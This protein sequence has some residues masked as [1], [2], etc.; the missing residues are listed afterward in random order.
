M[1]KA[2]LLVTKLH[3]PSLPAKWIKRPQLGQRLNEGLELGRPIT[4]ISAPAGFG[5]TTCVS[6]WLEKTTLPYSWLSLDASDDDPR[7]FF[8]YFIAALQQI[9]E[10]LGKEIEGVMLSG[11]LPPAEII[12]TKLMIDCLKTATPFLVI[13]DDFHLIQDRFI[14]QVFEHLLSNF[15]S[16]LHL[17]LITREDPS[18]P[19]G[20]IR[21]NNQLTE[22]RARD[23]RFTGN[24]IE[25]FLNE[26]MDLSLS[27]ADISFLENKTEGWIVGLQLAGLSIRDQ[28]NPSGFISGLSGSHRFILSYL[29]EQVLN[30]QPEEIQQFLLQTS[31]LDKLNAALCNAVTRHSDSDALLKRVLNANLFLIPLDDEQQWFR[32][33][34]LFADLLRNLQNTHRKEKTAELHRRASQWYAQAGMGSE[35]IQHALTAED[36]AA[37]VE[38]LENYAMGMIMQ[39]YAKTVN[40]WV[41]AIP[42]EWLSQSPR[43]HLAFAWMHL[44]RGAHSEVIQYLTQLEEIISGSQLSEE[45]KQSL[46]AEWLVMQSLLMNKYGKKDKSIALAEEALSITPEDHH[47]V[48]SLAYFGQASAYEPVQ[49]YDR[50]VDAYQKA[51]RHGRAANNLVTEM[52]ST[53][54][55][56]QLAFEH[57]Q[58]HLAF[59]IADPVRIQLEQS[60]SLP[61]ISTVVFGT[62]GEIHYQ[63]YLTAEARQFYR[64]ALQLSIWGGYKSGIVNCQVLLSRLSRIEGDLETAAAEIQKAVNQLNVE[65]A[66]YIRQEVISQQSRIFLA[67]NRPDAAE[68]ALQELGFSFRDQFSFPSLPPELEVSY[69]VGLM[70]NCSL[71]ILLHRA[72]AGHGPSSLKQGI[73]LA[74]QLIAGAFKRK[75]VVIAI[76]ALLLRAQM[77]ALRGNPAAGRKDYLAAL[78]LSEPEGF[79][80]VFVEQGLPVR[81]ALSDLVK[82]DRL[83]NIRSDYVKRILSAISQSQSQDQGLE[84]ET[85]LQVLPESLTDRE[86]DVLRC[87]VEGLK[88]K[89]IAAKLFISLNTVRYHV[90]A[91]YGKLNVNN[92]TQAIQKA[93]RLDIL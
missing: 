56:A 71:H 68:L 8:A 87:M 81:E 92:R 23:L 78:E 26:A 80:G 64:R 50:V 47:R 31:I 17:V 51:I 33:H 66:D 49:N 39:G 14:L 13:L 41:Q 46:K 5:K 48:R 6:E 2:N 79:I 58:L 53:S 57:G 34:H 9:D 35:A 29:T 70:Y 7:R 24:D 91:V 72:Y 69:S 44:L 90:K 20:R 40:S 36:Y 15:P 67:R 93:R 42:E 74:D 10:N 85:A 52:L 38:L 62:L 18:L 61:P 12:S 82:Q 55:L 21:A 37:A 54:G 88:Y 1:L 32:Y 45:D 43:T 3:R 30:Q 84:A 89:E 11:Q 25:R 28:A 60:G 19:L 75:H 76:E 27:K 4:L 77:H 22:I 86:L 59:E 63:W 83:G 65:I 73:N 16:A